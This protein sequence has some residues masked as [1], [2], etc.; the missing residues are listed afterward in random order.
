MKK[1]EYNIYEKFESSDPSYKPV[2]AFLSDEKGLMTKYLAE[3]N[4]YAP[5]IGDVVSAGGEIVSP[6][7]PVGEIAVW[8]GKYNTYGW[9]DWY[10][11]GEG[12]LHNIKGTE[13]MCSH[14]EKGNKKEISGIEVQKAVQVSY[15]EYLYIPHFR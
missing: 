2:I 5:S 9:Y 6:V 4:G 15:R 8:I 10:A 7:K 13:T 11:V 12:V 1:I 3:H 14:D